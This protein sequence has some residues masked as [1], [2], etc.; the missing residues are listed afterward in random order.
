MLVVALAARDGKGRLLM[1][2]RP[3]GKHHAGLWEFPG[4][5]VEDLENPREALAREI[6]EELA[7]TLGQGNL[8]PAGFAE[9]VASGGE[10]PIVLLLYRATHFDGEIAA[11]EGQAWGWFAPEEAARL[12]LA[13]MDAQLLAGLSG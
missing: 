5:K 6:R 4:G 10:M 9:S 12:P 3:A 1:Q 13:P 8:E 7:I 2:Q 11:Q